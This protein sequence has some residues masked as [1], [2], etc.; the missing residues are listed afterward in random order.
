MKCELNF[1]CW[2][3][4]LLPSIKIFSA[5]WCDLHGSVHSMDQLFILRACQ[6]FVEWT[7]QIILMSSCQ[8]G[9]LQVS[10][11]STGIWASR[12]HVFGLNAKP[13]LLASSCSHAITHDQIK[14]SRGTNRVNCFY[15]VPVH[16]CRSFI[17]NVCGLTVVEYTEE[18]NWCS[19]HN[20]WRFWF[21]WVLTL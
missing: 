12:L 20:G 16:V 7:N 15:F 3:Q 13:S 14:S 10:F 1:D 9:I 4:F 5:I 11:Q 21:P 2:I 17:T 18:F 8:C 6:Q 19:S